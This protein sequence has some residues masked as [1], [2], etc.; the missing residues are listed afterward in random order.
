MFRRIMETGVSLV[1]TIY[2]FWAVTKVTSTLSTDDLLKLQPK[3]NQN[4]IIILKSINLM[5]IVGLWISHSDV[6]CTSVRGFGFV[7]WFVV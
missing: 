3:P 2:I 7:G 6:I 5:V 1:L 4:P